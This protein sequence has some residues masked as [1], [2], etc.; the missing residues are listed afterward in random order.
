MKEKIV[1][2]AHGLRIRPVDIQNASG[3]L[4]PGAQASKWL[5]GQLSAGAAFAL[6][7]LCDKIEDGYVIPSTV[8]R[9]RSDKG[10]PRRP[11]DSISEPALVEDKAHEKKVIHSES[12]YGDW[13]DWME[14]CTW[15]HN[16]MTFFGADGV[17]G[18]VKKAGDATHVVI[19]ENEYEITKFNK[20]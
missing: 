5:G 10:V 3:G 2:R 17:A 14:M 19:G 13:Q 16:G 20:I 12:A 1:E 4:V 15:S 8:R 18:Y 7:L 6:D 9:E 11:A